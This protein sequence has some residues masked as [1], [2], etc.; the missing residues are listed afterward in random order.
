MGPVRNVGA[1]LKEK[2]KREES[3]SQSESERLAGK[4][5][6]R[7]EQRLV[8]SSAGGDIARKDHTRRPKLIWKGC[9]F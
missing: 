3:E 8:R 5:E 9:I 2:Q 4:A 6:S 1:L 7:V